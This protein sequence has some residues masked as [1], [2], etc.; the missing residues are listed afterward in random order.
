MKN[1]IALYNYDKAGQNIPVVIMK[2]IDFKEMNNTKSKLKAPVIIFTEDDI[3]N[4]GDVFAG[5][6]FHIKNH[7]TLIEGEDVLEKIKIS[8][9]HLRI[10]IEY[11]LRKLLINIREKYISKIDHNEMMGEVKAQMLYIIEG[12][13][14]L[15]KK[16][17]DIST[18]ENIKT[19][20][21]IYKTN[22]SILNNTTTPNID[23]VY[24]LLLDLTKKVDNL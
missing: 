13:I 8:L 5:E 12:M 7:T 16:N 4:G 19:H 23:D 22:L 9:P 1:T 21:E 3:K 14:G 6:F 24:T 11:E 15:K 2:N 18:I 17:I 20:T 10:H